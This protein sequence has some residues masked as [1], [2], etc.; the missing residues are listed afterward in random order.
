MD[1]RME[2]LNEIRSL[3]PEAVRQMEDMLGNPKT[4][5]MVKIRIMEMILDRTFGR[6]E[7]A[8]KLSTTQQNVEAAQA[9]LEA[10]FGHVK[11]E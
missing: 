8:V 5:P 2:S 9:R 4:S 11:I 1:E 3:A 10:I 7:A 6:P